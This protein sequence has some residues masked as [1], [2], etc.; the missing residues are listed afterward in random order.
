DNLVY[1][2]G[3][4]PRR[5]DEHPLT[6]A[7]FGEP[8]AAEREED[9]EAGAGDA[10]AEPDGALQD[11]PEAPATGEAQAEPERETTIAGSIAAVV[12]QAAAAIAAK[13]EKAEAASGTWA[14]QAGEDE[15]VPAPRPRRRFRFRALGGPESV[16]EGVRL[17][18]VVNLSLSLVLPPNPLG[19]AAAIGLMRGYA[20]GRTLTTFWAGT[21]LFILLLVG[22]GFAAALAA[23]GIAAGPDATPPSLWQGPVLLGAL[24]FGA[25]GAYFV[26]QWSYLSG[27]RISESLEEGSEQAALW[28]GWTLSWLYIA[29]VALV[30][31]LVLP[32]L[33]A[34]WFMPPRPVATLPAVAMTE[35]PPSSRVHTADGL[36][37]I[38]APEP[39]SIV[40]V[41]GG[42]DA[43]LGV[44]LQ[45]SRENPAGKVRVSATRPRDVERMNKRF[46]LLQPDEE[47]IRSVEAARIGDLEGRRIVLWSK[48]PG[49]MTGQ[50]LLSLQDETRGYQFSC[51]APGP[52]FEAIRPEC[53]RMAQSLIITSKS[54]APGTPEA[55]TTDAGA[56]NTAA[57]S[58]PSAAKR[59]PGS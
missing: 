2:A 8:E 53:D 39:W 21:Q 31:V 36:L 37:S 19:V 45:G 16:P 41:E 10:H 24:A 58:P 17:L 35:A 52:G 48:V 51:A 56:G 14:P 33:G 46:D 34:D 18:G 59:S 23:A 42:D 49:G 20:W 12:N 32:R 3:E 40:A 25:L 7:L 13:R 11:E 27:P 9:E 50:I 43:K 47:T 44:L 5:A 54:H 57:T 38:E 30:A 26:V 55:G 29:G 15:G 4:E 28:W 6:Q 22:T 1:L